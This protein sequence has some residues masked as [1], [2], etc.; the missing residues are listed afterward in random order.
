MAKD[1]RQ[2]A[3]LGVHLLETPKEGVIIHN[4]AM[5]SLIM[6]IKEK[7]SQDPVLQYLKKKVSQGMVKGFELKQNG[8]LYCQNKLC[9]P[10]TSGIRKRIMEE[11]HHSRYFIH[12][13]STK[14][15]H[16]LKGMFWWGG[17]KK[18]LAEFVAPCPNY[19]QVKVEHQK[20]GGYMQFIESPTW[21]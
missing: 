2:L 10:N 6:K 7:Q 1:L 15:Y 18:D 9:V 5:S 8:V 17:M 12:P 14:M 16:D 4:A 11:A 20:P 3:S 19:Q 21:K 13:G